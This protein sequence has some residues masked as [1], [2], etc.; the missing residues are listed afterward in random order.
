MRKIFNKTE[1]NKKFYANNEI[2]NLGIKFLLRKTIDLKKGWI[3]NSKEI[4]NYIIMNQ[5]KDN[6]NSL[7]KIILPPY[8]K[9]ELICNLLNDILQ[10]AKRKSSLSKITKI[11]PLTG[12]AKGFYSYPKFSRFE[13]K[14]WA[15]RGWLPGI[16]K[17]SW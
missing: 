7:N 3:T 4:P 12:R 6:K 14:Y 11:C 10:K 17:S 15:G 5:K 13:F 1:K 2:K 16:R 8:I 9:L